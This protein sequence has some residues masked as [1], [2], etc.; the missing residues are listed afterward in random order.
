[1]AELRSLH[2][3]TVAE[4][5]SSGLEELDNIESIALSVLWK[6]GEVTTGCS[7]MSTANLA[8]LV[9]MLDNYQRAMLRE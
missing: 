6:D 4:I 1:M 5:F 9:L 7:N 3:T 8:L 2:G